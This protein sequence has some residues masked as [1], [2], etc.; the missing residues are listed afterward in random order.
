[1]AFNAMIRREGYDVYRK[2]D[3]TLRPF[4]RLTTYDHRIKTFNNK[5]MNYPISIVSLAEAGFYS[6]GKYDYVQ[7][8]RCDGILGDWEKND[9]PWLEHFKWFPGC[10]FIRDNKWTINKYRKYNPNYYQFNCWDILY[11]L[12]Y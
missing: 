4:T 11:F 1:M 7:C 2:I 8:F 10:Y 9:I 12:T 5:E 6:I 3:P